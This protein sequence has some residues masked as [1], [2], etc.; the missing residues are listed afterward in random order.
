[1]TYFRISVATAATIWLLVAARSVLQPLVIAI[2]IWF[3]LTAT[4]RAYTR[5]IRGPSAT[6]TRLAKGMSVLTVVVVVV[7]LSMLVA[8]NVERVRD[9][10]PVYEANL[11]ALIRDLAMRLG[12]GDAVGLRDMIGRIDLSGAAI[13]LLGSAAGFLSAAIIVI[14][15]V[16]F[17]FVEDRVAD[18]KLAALI[19][20]PDRRAEVEHL[21]S[22]IFR[23]IETY[24]G[25]K[26]IIGIVQ[27]VPT[28]IILA[29]VGVDAA[30]FW[31]VVIFFF[32]FIPTVG[33][34]VGIIFPSLMALLQFQDPATFLVVL[35]LMAT[36][37]LLASNALEPR[38]MGQSLNLSPL[39]IFLAIFAGAALWGIVGA[40]IVVPLLAICAIVFARIPSLRSIAIL[41]S[42]DGRIEHDA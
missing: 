11:D 36:V 13:T 2:F 3:V 4:A 1:M 20:T 6:P 10:L 32:S 17:I 21:I 5:L 26:L 24:L 39:A 29:V 41:L 25:I 42:S 30:A 9:A 27:A 31:A 12:A 19:A 37:Q 15:Y 7:L 38:L 33:S 8:V 16:I 40:L 28:Y 35:G 23:E 18:R 22:R 34:L 14:F